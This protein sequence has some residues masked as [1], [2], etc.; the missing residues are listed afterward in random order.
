MWSNTV[1]YPDYA[2]GEAKWHISAV[3]DQSIAGVIMMVEGGFVTFGVLA[4]LFLQWAQQD[5]ERQR[6]LDLAESR[7]VP[8]S[9]ARAAR[10]A[11]AG[12]GARLEER[13][14]GSH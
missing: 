12:Q 4:W 2:A 10:A 6:L 13:I 3:T 1:F 5:T 8:L 7:G 14:K 11:A 9:E